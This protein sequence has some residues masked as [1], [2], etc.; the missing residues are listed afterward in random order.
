[1]LDS[2]TTST[3][4]R[5]GEFNLRHSKSA[6]LI[7]AALIRSGAIIGPVNVAP[8]VF[9]SLILFQAP[10]YIL[11]HNSKRRLQATSTSTSTASAR[12]ATAPN[13]V[14]QPPSPS[15]PSRLRRSPS[16]A[17]K[18]HSRRRSSMRLLF[19]LFDCVSCLIFRF[20]SRSHTHT[21][22]HTHSSAPGI[23]VDDAASPVRC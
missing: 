18:R 4:G 22:T 8:M 5:G 11:T 16:A 17:P 21:H 10:P 12:T 3:L 19:R 20:S 2:K 15:T 23:V 6:I 13:V 1:M 7:A 14:A 9:E